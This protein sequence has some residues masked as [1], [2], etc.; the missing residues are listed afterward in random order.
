MSPNEDP[1]TGQKY[2]SRLGL[3]GTAAGMSALLWACTIVNNNGKGDDGGASSLFGEGGSK[4]NTS[5]H[6]SGGNS[7]VGEGGS[8]VGTGGGLIGVAGSALGGNAGASAR[9]VAGIAV[10]AGAGNTVAGAGA[11]GAAGNAAVA[12]ARAVGAAGSGAAGSGA[13]AGAS[14]IAAGGSANA[15]ASAIAAGGSLAGAAGVGGQPLDCVAPTTAG[16]AGAI[17]STTAGGLWNDVNTWIGGKVPSATDSVVIVG[18]VQ[19]DVGAGDATVTC[20]S[21]T[22]AKEGVLRSAAYAARTIQVNGDFVNYGAVRNGPPYASYDSATLEVHV[23]GRFFQLGSYGVVST[24]FDGGQDQGIGVADGTALAGTF[25]DDNPASALRACTAISSGGMT[26]TLGP[27]NA[28]PGL[29]DLGEQVLTL[30]AGDFKVTSGALRASKIVGVAGATM[31]VPQITAVGTLVLDGDVRT[32]ASTIDGSV[33]V[34]ATGV[35]YNIAYAAPTL[36][37]KG[38]LE[39]AGIVRRGPGYAA[40]GEG[41]LTLELSGNLV[42]NGAFTPTAIK[43]VGAAVQTI[44]QAAGK[45]LSGPFTDT[46]PTT[47]IV[48][49]SDLAF[50]ATT[51]D[52]GG[53]TL[54][55]GSKTLTLSAGDFKITSGVLRAGKIV[56][57]EGATMNIPQITAVGTLVLDGDVRTDASVIDGSVK[58]LATGVLYNV[59]NAAPTLTIKGSIENAGLIRRGPG[60]AAYGEGDLTIDLTGNLSQ[61]GPYTPTATKLSGSVAQTIALGPSQ[62]LSGTFTDTTPSTPIVAGSNWT[63]NAATFDLGATGTL[64]LG[65]YTLTHPSGELK[66]ATGTLKV[67]DITGDSAGAGTFT[68]AAITPNSG[69]LT[70]RQHYPT[71]SVTITGNLVVETGAHLYNEVY[72]EAHVTVTGTVTQRGT[73]GSGP[74]YASYDSG[75][76]YLNGV[77]LANW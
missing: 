61:N 22:I 38:N 52:L 18:E 17:K 19:V 40:Y 75:M 2:R 63:V 49:G 36:A 1:M 74:G 27:S 25:V 53:G 48:A 67:D 54:D 39:T 56:G 57:V 14:A 3:V 72:V 41:D 23:G 4:A 34:L 60:F 58:V 35:L 5:G 55:M 71:S 47:A 8:A 33:K 11:I 77:K 7:S 20:A 6:K 29:L 24:H 76:V 69:T 51:F 73:I 44:T 37:I 45:V 28:Q 64:D 21:V 43:L 59:G 15:G 12:G 70:V 46:T 50:G 30:S 66:I 32:D 13:A 9:G 42:Q 16:P 31:N 65:S 68:I 10:I 26:L 62:I